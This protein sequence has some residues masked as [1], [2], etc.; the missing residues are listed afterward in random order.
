M[1]KETA[2]TKFLKCVI[3]HSDN[4]D[5]PPLQSYRHYV[6]ELNTRLACIKFPFFFIFHTVN[7]KI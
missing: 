1:H 3:R 6:S 7:K 2:D 5:E 4:E